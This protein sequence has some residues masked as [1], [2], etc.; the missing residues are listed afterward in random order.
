MNNRRRRCMKNIPNI[1]RKI[2]GK[3]FHE[4][5]ILLAKML[6]KISWQIWKFHQQLESHFPFFHLS[7]HHTK[8]RFLLTLACFKWLYL[9]VS[10]LFIVRINIQNSNDLKANIF[11]HLCYRGEKNFNLCEID[12]FL[13]SFENIKYETLRHVRIHSE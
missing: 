9:P 6:L 10:S 5:A 1:Y 13:C 12:L 11:L 4:C 3:R 8:I 2:I 7:F